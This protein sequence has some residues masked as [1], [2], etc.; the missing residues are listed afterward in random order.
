MKRALVVLVVVGVTRMAA[1]GSASIQVPKYADGG[2]EMES[3]GIWL[4]DGGYAK[5]TRPVPATYCVT[6]GY[7]NE[8][9]CCYKGEVVGAL[10]GGES[11]RVWDA[12]GQC[13]AYAVYCPGPSVDL[14]MPRMDGGSR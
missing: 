1:A 4:D 6:S 2:R 7:C 5:V 12:N 8:M 11:F 9:T 14:P 3:Y 10:D 13:T